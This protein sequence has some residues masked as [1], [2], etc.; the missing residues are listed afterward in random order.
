METLIQKI[1]AM[2]IVTLREAMIFSGLTKDDIL[3]LVAAD[4]SLKLFDNETGI[5]YNENAK[6]HC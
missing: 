1:H 2:E 3:A 4:K 5:W 6:G